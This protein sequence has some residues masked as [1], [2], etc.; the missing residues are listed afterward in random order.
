MSLRNCTKASAIPPAPAWN[1]NPSR[2]IPAS[3][4]NR[5]TYS[6]I[7]S[8]S[9]LLVI[10]VVPETIFDGSPTESTSTT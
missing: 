5:A 8:R 6:A 1:E 10:W 2:M 9:G 7:S 3:R 4:R